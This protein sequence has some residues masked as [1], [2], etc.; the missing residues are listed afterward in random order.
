MATLTRW[1]PFRDAF[2]LQDELNR[3][4][5]YPG[6]SF[7]PEGEA[8]STAWA[9][10]VD[11]YEDAEGITL[12]AEV[13]GLN[14]GEIDVRIENATLTLKGERKLEKEDHK[15]NYRRV[16]RVYGAFSRSF[17]LPTTVDAEKVRAEHKNGVLS[18][19]LPKREETKPRQ[20]RVNVN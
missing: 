6:R 20:I 19:F 18:I 16:E 13:P 17:S 14:P 11:I 10:P 9:P 2:R 1:T 8:L 12:K 4:L 7:A 5:D 15:E 3:L